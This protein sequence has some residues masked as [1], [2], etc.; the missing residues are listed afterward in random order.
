MLESG[1]GRAAA[2]ALAGRPE[3]TGPALTGPT[4]LLFADDVVDPVPAGTDGT[5]PVPAG[6]GLAPPPE[7]DRLRALTVASWTRDAG[8]R[9]AR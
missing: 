4:A 2:R 3:V 6:P 1:V 7:L 5:V 8:P 9:T